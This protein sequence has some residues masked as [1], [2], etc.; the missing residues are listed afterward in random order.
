MDA[1]ARRRRPRN[2]RGSGHARRADRLIFPAS[3]GFDRACHG[4]ADILLHRR[5]HCDLHRTN[6]GR[7]NSRNHHGWTKAHA[8][9]AKHAGHFHSLCAAISGRDVS[10][11]WHELVAAPAG[12]SSGRHNSH[13]DRHPRSDPV[14]EDPGNPPPRHADPVAAGRPALPRLPRIYHPRGLGTRRRSARTAHG[15]LHRRPCRHFG[16]V[17]ARVH[18]D[19]GDSRSGRHVPATVPQIPKSARSPARQ[20][21]WRA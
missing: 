19:F 3:A 16:R 14:L 21:I 5:R 18:G 10:P 15:A 12:R 4:R 20:G 6:L 11:S 9:D 13:L 2:S 8:P 1:L 17:A 7:R